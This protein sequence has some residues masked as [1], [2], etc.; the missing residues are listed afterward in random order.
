VKVRRLIIP[1]CAIWAPSPAIGVTC[2]RGHLQ[3]GGRG[4]SILDGESGR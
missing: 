4:R 3:S 1:H 2:N